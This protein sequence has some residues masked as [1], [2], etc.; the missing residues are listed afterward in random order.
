MGFFHDGRATLLPFWGAHGAWVSKSLT[1]GHK[2]FV[3]SGGVKG[4][5]EKKYDASV[6]LNQ[7]DKWG[8]G[9]ALVGME[10]EFLWKQ[11]KCW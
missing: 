5:V 1:G 6:T 8:G 3:W 7:G 11:G 10:G 2:N 9:E 4:I